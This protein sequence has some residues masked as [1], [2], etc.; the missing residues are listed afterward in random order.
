M[1][2]TNEQV[3]ASSTGY[4]PDGDIELAVGLLSG[5]LQQETVPLASVVD[6]GVVRSGQMPMDFVDG[7]RSRPGASTSGWWPGASW[8]LS[9][10][11]LFFAF[12]MG[13]LP[14]LQSA[15]GPRCDHLSACDIGGTRPLVV[16]IV[17][18]VLK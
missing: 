8:F 12:E 1:F 10:S 14:D 9:L 17:I 16:T 13:A 5:P 11:L 7:A 2:I 4:G 3:C 6:V 15:I 18:C